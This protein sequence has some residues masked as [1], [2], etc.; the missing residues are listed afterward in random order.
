[1]A[2][3]PH[4]SA[5]DADPLLSRKWYGRL[6]WGVHAIMAVSIAY[7]VLYDD[8]GLEGE[9][10]FTPEAGGPGRAPRARRAVIVLQG[11]IASTWSRLRRRS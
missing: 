6:K 7:L 11:A 4:M 9:H 5:A 10:V 8:F 3:G 2:R 1:M